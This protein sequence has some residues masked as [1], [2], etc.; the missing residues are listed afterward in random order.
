MKLDYNCGV[1]EVIS[2]FSSNLTV[3]RIR[4]VLRPIESVMPILSK[5]EQVTHLYPYWS[6]GVKVPRNDIY[7]ICLVSIAIAVRASNFWE[8]Q[9]NI[10]RI[11]DGESER[12]NNRR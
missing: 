5:S 3:S 9:P 6:F 2:N 4:G 11:W 12:E 8:D 7:S 1:F 10:G